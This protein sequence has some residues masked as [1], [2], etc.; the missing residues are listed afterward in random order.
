MT[1]VLTLIFAMAMI[2]TVL[3]AFSYGG[4]LEKY[5][6]IALLV[7]SV[8]SPFAQSSGF[9]SPEYGL[10]VIDIFVLCLLTSAA[11]LSGRYWPMYAA[12][13]QIPAVLW[14]LVFTENGAASQAYADI[15]VLWSY[16]V[17]GALAVGTLSEC[18]NKQT[19]QDAEHHIS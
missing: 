19:D 11:L 13:F 16:L 18:K 4:P 14:H 2:G 7:A 9:A 1:L 6:A 3:V 17:L 12:G 10:L 8:A 15:S 5:I